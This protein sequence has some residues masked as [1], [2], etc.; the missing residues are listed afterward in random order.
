MK[1]YELCLCMEC[2]EVL[3]RANRACPSCT[4]TQLAPLSRFIPTVMDKEVLFDGLV[5]RLTDTQAEINGRIRRLQHQTDGGA[6]GRKTRRLLPHVS[7]KV[8][9]A[10]GGSKSYGLRRSLP[11]A[12]A[13]F[14]N[15]L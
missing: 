15:I 10:N 2:E 9:E 7:G 8:R 13:K 14:L 11:L 3:T 12:I 4:S 5:A 6:R 1:L